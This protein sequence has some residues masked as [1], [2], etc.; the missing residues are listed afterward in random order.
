MAQHISGAPGD[1]KRPRKAAK[2][3]PNEEKS[4]KTGLKMPTT[5]NNMARVHPA[6]PSH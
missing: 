2:I 6:Q 5:T 4:A 3:L 1:A